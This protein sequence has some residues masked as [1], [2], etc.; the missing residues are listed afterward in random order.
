MYSVATVACKEKIDEVQFKPGVVM[1][2]QNK[3][4]IM[5]LNLEMSVSAR[6]HAQMSNLHRTETHLKVLNGGNNWNT[7]IYIVIAACY[8]LT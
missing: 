2:E 3:T 8:E 4:F 7:V 1:M 5:V 6:A